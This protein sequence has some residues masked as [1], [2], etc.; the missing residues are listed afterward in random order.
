MRR[1]SY[2]WVALAAGAA[3]LAIAPRD[4]APRLVT[5]VAHP[6]ERTVTAPG[7]LKASRSFRC[8]AALDAVLN[9]LEPEGTRIQTGQVVARLDVSEVADKLRDRTINR[10]IAQCDLAIQRV[11]Y[12]LEGY[13]TQNR[14]AF[15]E[16]DLAVAEL[17][18]DYTLHAVDYAE[19]VR[20]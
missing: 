14:V 17:A 2:T 3:A 1:L 9:A 20:G 16:A 12:E 10:D 18:R 11:L 4:G 6:Y 15:A 5:V 7:T 19:Y 13:E 8:F